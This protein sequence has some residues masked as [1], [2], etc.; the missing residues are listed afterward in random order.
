M[1]EIISKIDSKKLAI[2]DKDDNF[3]FGLKFYG[4]KED[5]IQ[6]GAFRYNNGTKLRA[7]RH[8]DRE[9]VITKTQEI[10]IV[11]EGKAVVDIYDYDGS[12]AYTDTLSSGMFCIV[13]HGGVGYLVTN[14]NTKML[15]V[16]LGDYCITNDSEDREL[17]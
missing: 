2:I 9:R 12:I 16:K 6:V 1:R 14:D 15:E 3:D 5:L 4:T 11:L 10:L 13:Y 7:H 17:I 8:I